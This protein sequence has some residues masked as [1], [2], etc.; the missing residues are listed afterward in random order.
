MRTILFKRHYKII[1][2]LTT[3]IVLLV[4]MLGNTQ[5]I[6]YTSK[7]QL[8]EEICATCYEN[9]VDIFDDTVVHEIEILTNEDTYDSMIET[10]K[11]TGEKE[12]FSVDVT[13][14]GVLV[15]NVGLRLKGNASLSTVLG[16]AMEDFGG[17]GGG[18]GP[19]D[20]DSDR[21]NGFAP[22][23]FGEDFEDMELP[24]GF[25]PQQDFM[26]MMGGM[27][28][29]GKEDVP[30]LIKFDEFVDGQCYQGYAEIAVR[31]SGISDNAS[32]LH[33]P[34]TNY[35]IESLG[36]PIS[37]TSYASVQLTE[38]SE[39]IMY[40]LAQ[41]VDQIFIDEYFPNSDGVLYKINQVGND[42]SYLGDDPTLYLDIFSQETNVNDADYTPLIQF[43]K[44]V[45]E[46]SDEEFA[47]NLD[48]YFDVTAFADYLAIHNILANNDSL[49]GMGNNY[50]LYHD[51]DTGI[52]TI[53]TWDTNESL[54]KLSGG[55]GG[56]GT[57]SGSGNV[58]GAETDIYW[59]NSGD[60]GNFF[61]QFEEDSTEETSEEEVVVND[62][63]LPEIN[64][65][66]GG[67]KM[68]MGSHLLKERFLETPEFLELY[69]ER[70]E[71]IYEQL[72]GTD[73]LTSK[74]DEYAD[75]LTGYNS[76]NDLFDQ[77]AYDAAVEIV[78]QFLE[79]RYQY[80]NNF[81]TGNS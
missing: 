40:V 42:F 31:T 55:M 60:F 56:G 61:D 4:A 68:G 12:Y 70:Y 37:E 53:L 28:D 48:D 73:L 46:A 29:G 57:M 7:Q 78:L 54:G 75:L 33:E 76:T 14:D 36:I 17:D 15:E 38:D 16:V 58:S 10:F 81:F 63:M 44:F 49:A 51:F 20:K 72:L 32:M 43:M 64:N 1:F 39:P 24:E 59:E 22:P 30:Y 13:I 6:A 69:E 45:T 67:D 80:L 52:F 5:I 3:F 65:S 19:G 18:K 9:D 23:A 71:I 21:D 62:S 50:Y 35:A 34:I 66:K 47:E 79:E 2:G 41:Q 26:D 25:E 74:V 8:E 27:G 11:E 77:E